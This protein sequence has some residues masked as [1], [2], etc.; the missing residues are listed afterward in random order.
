MNLN[1]KKS[2]RYY[3]IYLG[4]KL[5]SIKSLRKIILASI[6]E[7]DSDNMHINGEKQILNKILDY[8]ICDFI[9]VGANLGEWSSLII[10]KTNS[11]NSIVLYEPNK[12]YHKRLNK[13]VSNNKNIKYYPFAISDKEGLVNF[14]L[15]GVFSKIDN[16]SKN[17]VK[18][19]NHKTIK[20]NHNLSTNYFIKIDAEGF[21]LEILKQFW[22]SGLCENS[23]IQV[24]YG[25]A[26][27]SLHVQIN[28]FKK[29]LPMHRSF[30]VSNR[31]L[32]PLSILKL[33]DFCDPL[34]NI[35]FV[36]EQFN[37]FYK[38]IDLRN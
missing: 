20:K 3:I 27:K 33:Y 29:L 5:L 21:D 12:N 9:D 32:L 35:L 23:F 8:G 14:K 16:K 13:L 17:L 4:N 37:D 1:L 30:I 10:R 15:D 25:E 19:I 38:E 34:L 6:L 26:Q 36:P 24:E 11:F 18:S 2:I 22:K 31:K 28:D 7:T